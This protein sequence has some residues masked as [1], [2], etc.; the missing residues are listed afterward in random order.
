[1]PG[2]VE[3]RN[4]GRVAVWPCPLSPPKRLD[5]SCSSQLRVA[6]SLCVRPHPVIC[7][8]VCLESPTSGAGRPCQECRSSEWR[9]SRGGS[10]QA[11]EK[12]RC[13]APE[14]QKEVVACLKPTPSSKTQGKQDFAASSASHGC[15]QLQPWIS[16]RVKFQFL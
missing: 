3:E 6:H 1:M 12:F 10:V 16:F 4:K 7:V 13:S 8:R 2:M 15:L 14:G 9:G 5:P 11:S